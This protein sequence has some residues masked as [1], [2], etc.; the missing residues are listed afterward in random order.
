M[1]V[2]TEGIVVSVTPCYL[3]EESRWFVFIMPQGGEKIQVELQYSP[4]IKQDLLE[5]LGPLKIITVQSID[6]A[7]HRLHLEL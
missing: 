5:L 1:R 4:E 2:Y 6:K 3:Y 7:G